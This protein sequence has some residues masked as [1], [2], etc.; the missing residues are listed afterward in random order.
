MTSRKYLCFSGSNAVSKLIAVIAAGFFAL[1]PIAD[2][3]ADEIAD[4]AAAQASDESGQPIYFWQH[5]F[6]D[7][8]HDLV[9]AASADAQP[10]EIKRV[11]YGGGKEAGCHYTGLALARGDD[12]GWHLAW[13]DSRGLYYA[14][15]DGA[16]W[17][18]SPSKRLSSS[19]IQQISLDISVSQVKL[20]W[21]EESGG[22]VKYFEAVSED[23]GRSWEPLP[24]H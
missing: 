15:M 20:V 21:Q 1:A 7:G 3:H 13:A 6:A 16:A 12:W 14:R 18:S 11:T 4:C 9:M 2:V 24:A 10:P 22:A 5:T 19:H 8:T 23:E 17:V